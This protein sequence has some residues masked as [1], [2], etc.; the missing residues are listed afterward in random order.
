MSQATHYD[1]RSCIDRYTQGTP[2]SLSRA[3]IN[4]IW[5]NLSAAIKE[6]PLLQRGVSALRTVMVNANA[7]GGGEGFET[8]RANVE[9]ALQQVLNAGK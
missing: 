1:G 7:A 3:D 6:G 8:A 2:V 9:A 5:T 4:T